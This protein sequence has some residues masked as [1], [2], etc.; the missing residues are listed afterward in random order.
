MAIQYFNPPQLPKHPA[1]TQVII[2]PP[3]R[4]T[5]IVGAQ[6]AVDAA[7]TLVGGGDAA[8]Q[9]GKAID[10]LT[11]ALEAAGARLDNLVKVTI[12]VVS[13][14]DLQVAQG[15]WTERWGAR[16][17]PPAVSLLWVAGLANPEFLVEIDA[18]AAL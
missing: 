7:G 18:L 17:N 8:L 6:N 15:V 13:R 3:G 2:L 10:N 9:T 16:P 4:R 12:C 1:A 5:I 11:V 14:K